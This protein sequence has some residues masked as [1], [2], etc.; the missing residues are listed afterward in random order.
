MQGVWGFQAE[1]RFNWN[2]EQYIDL[3]N[4]MNDIVIKYKS[5]VK[6]RQCDKKSEK[7]A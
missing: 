3:E 6:Y 5:L 2:Q 1:V 7:G 4:F